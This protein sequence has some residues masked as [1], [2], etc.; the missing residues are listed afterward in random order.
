MG[1]IYAK[2]RGARQDW[3]SAEKCSL[4]DLVEAVSF[5][6]HNRQTCKAKLESHRKMCSANTVLFSASH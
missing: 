5:K 4:F 6:S 1:A 3:G 2:R